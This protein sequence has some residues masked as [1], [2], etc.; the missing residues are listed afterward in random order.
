MTDT[1]DPHYE[2]TRVTDADGLFRKLL[3][4]RR[5]FPLIG[6]PYIGR[7]AKLAHFKRWLTRWMNG[8]TER[9]LEIGSG[10]GVFSFTAAQ[11]MPQATVIG[12]EIN[13]AEAVACQKLAE[14][15][16][17]TNLSFCSENLKSQ[18]FQKHFDLI[19]CL[20]VFEHVHDDT[21]LASEIGRCLRDG[22]SLLAHV[23]SRYW[24]DLNGQMQ[25]VP[26]KKRG[27]STPVTCET[28]TPPMSSRR[29]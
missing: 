27:E 17:T 1:F 15:Q 5:L 4:K 2:T 23:P 22:G 29:C 7:R 24:L 8:K 26:T 12:L 14:Y 19:F 9:I 6:E 21:E 20:D 25:T 18:R 16:R 11:A 28:V 13:Q 3:A 10:E